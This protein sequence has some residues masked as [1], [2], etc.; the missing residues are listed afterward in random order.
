[1]NI[2]SSKKKTKVKFDTATHCTE[3]ITDSHWCLGTY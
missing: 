2:A 1:M 3:E